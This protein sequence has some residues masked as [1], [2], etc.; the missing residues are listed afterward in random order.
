METLPGEATLSE[1][2]MLPSEKGSTL[3]G[4]NLLPLPFRVDTF[5]NGLCEHKS[6]QEVTEIISLVS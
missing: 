4:K 3:K 6:K 5:Q 2:V 1:L